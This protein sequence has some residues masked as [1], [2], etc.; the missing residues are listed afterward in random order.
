MSGGSA[1]ASRGTG[2]ECR[3][4]APNIFNKS[5]CSSCFK[6]KEEHTAEALESNRVRT[7]VPSFSSSHFFNPFHNHLLYFL[8]FFNFILVLILF[9]TRVKCSYSQL[10]CPL[11]GQCNYMLSFLPHCVNNTSQR[12]VT[13]GQ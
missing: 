12:D 5:K 9:W 6:Q 3:K 11:Q 2:A 10:Y 1:C 7:F 4:F 8:F 13:A